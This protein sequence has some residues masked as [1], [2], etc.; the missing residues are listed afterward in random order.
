MLAPKRPY[1]RFMPVYAAFMAKGLKQN[2]KRAEIVRR[3]AQKGAN[4]DSS[5]TFLS[6]KFPE[7]EIARMMEEG[8]TREQAI[9]ALLW[10]Y[11]QTVKSSVE[12]SEI[13]RKRD[14]EKAKR[15]K[16]I[17]QIMAG[18]TTE[19][20]NEIARKREAGKT[21]EER[22]EIGREAWAGKTPEERSEIA[23]RRALA[24]TPEE[25]SEI[26]RKARKTW[27]EKSTPEE[28]SEIA[29]KAWEKRF[30]KVSYVM[31]LPARNLLSK[32]EVKQHLDKYMKHFWDNTAVNEAAK[33][34]AYSLKSFRKRADFE[35][36]RMQF[37]LGVL[38]ALSRWDGTV[39]LDRLVADSVIFHLIDYFGSEKKY[40]GLLVNMDIETA[41]RVIKRRRR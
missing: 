5:N 12:W 6:M 20:R 30:S 10:K 29:R 32:A 35:D 23:R 13:A 26:A 28:R 8:K 40:H 25:R 19:E 21:P 33:L 38:H 7:K 36:I 27:L 1:K 11:R 34:R 3:L 39:D 9:D 2:V 22:S 14:V 24:K 18:K 41:E 17:A 15:G 37:Q 16:T 4:T 31:D